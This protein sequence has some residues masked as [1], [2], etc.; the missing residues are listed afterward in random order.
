MRERSRKNFVTDSTSSE[1]YLDEISRLRAVLDSAVDGIITIDERGRMEAANPA[2][3]RLFGYSVS[4]ML[5][6]NVSMLM[7]SPDRDQHDQYLSNYLR[8]GVRQIIGVG[9]EVLGRRKDGSTF[10]LYLAVSEVSFGHRKVFTGFVHDLTDLRQA[11]QDLA[12]RDAQ[13][14]FMVEN[15]PAAAAYVNIRTGEVRFNPVVQQMT[16]HSVED[17]SNLDTCFSRF[18]GDRATRLRRH[19]ELSQRLWG[20]QPVRLPVLRT[21]GDLR[22]I[23]FRGYR[24]D[25]HEVWLL[26]DVTER[27]RQETELRIRDQAI[28]ASN[29]GVVIADATKDGFPIVFVNRAFEQMTGYSAAEAVGRGCHLICGEDSDSE[30]VQQ[31]QESITEPRAFR[32]TVQCVRKDGQFFW[33]EVSVAP[34]C[35]SSGKVTHLVAVM[36]D[37]SERRQA[38]QQLL[39]SER[40]AAI[41]QMVTGLAHESRNALQRA[42]ACMDML[43]LDLEDQPEQLELTEKIRRA[44][45]DLHRYYEEVRNYAAPINLECRP[46]D[47][48][49]LWQD[50]WRNLEASRKGRDFQLIEAER[51]ID[52]VCSVDE[53]RL[54][55][56]FRNIM[57]NA[58]SA[59]PDPGQ[60]HVSCLHASLGSKP[61]LK[62]VFRDNGP[63]FTRQSAESAF[64]PFFTTKQKGT[65]LG[66]AIAKR[67]VEAHG[68]QISIS[69]PATQTQGGAEIVVALPL[70]EQLH[71]FQSS[72]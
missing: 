21:D 46:V 31:F 33:N 1:A 70:G 64:Q 24:Y 65:G 17:L 39:Q 26:H 18:F 57:E 67:I 47:V 41:G 63:G 23:E 48:A 5:G 52:T 12:K 29:E 2:A 37:V 66:M 13:L 50:T 71:A 35:S 49:K 28:Q 16:G 68:G 11:Q 36:E 30:A 15:L 44:L 43:S 25:G 59:C 32:S 20:E 38:Q 9:R 27:D 56:V 8:T 58:L 40:L 55:Q 42:Q 72:G 69:N 60:L 14:E 6:R 61:A 54:D 22:V 7:P 4:E 3:E 53:H 51:D 19:Y 34:V 10:P 45:D 62:I